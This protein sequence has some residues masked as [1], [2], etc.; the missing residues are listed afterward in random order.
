MNQSKNVGEF[1]SPLHDGA[2]RCLSAGHA[3]P[4]A[5]PC[6]VL[7]HEKQ[8]VF[9]RVMIEAG[10]VGVVELIEGAHLVNEVGLV[11]RAGVSEAL[12]SDLA[13]G[14]F[15]IGKIYIAETAASKTPDDAIFLVQFF[16]DEVRVHGKPPLLLVIVRTQAVL[17]VAVNDK[18]HH[19]FLPLAAGD[20]A[21][22]GSLVLF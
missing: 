5:A 8:G 20:G 22:F 13:F 17:D 14:Q 15:V 16:T 10:D 3:A 11:L 2:R 18:V 21:R 6:T 1:F 19:L 4:K 12:D 9:V 7:H